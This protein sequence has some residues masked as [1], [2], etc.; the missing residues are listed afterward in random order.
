[1]R[2][3]LLADIH[4][5]SAALDAVLQDIPD[6]DAYWVLGDLVALGPDPVGVMERLHTLKGLQMI[7]GNTDRYVTHNDRPAP[8]IEAAKNNPGLLPALVEVANTFA[9]TQGMIT[10][11]GWFDTISQLPLDFEYTLPDGTRFL[12]VHAAPGKDDGDGIK[13]ETAPGDLFAGC[14]ADFVCVGHT[15]IPFERD[16]Q[17]IYVANP[18]AISLSLLPNRKA[19]Y[20]ILDANEKGYS[21]SFRQVDYDRAAVV[22]QLHRLKHPA[23][24][25]I[26]KHITIA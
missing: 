17:G 23:R 25:F 2:I 20:A 12:A 9:W 16:I 15:H 1:M 5:N 18:G 13:P 4:G 10:A 22:H 7:R 14:K 19:C 11:G 6:A 26:I 3:A 24:Y 21:I 8:T